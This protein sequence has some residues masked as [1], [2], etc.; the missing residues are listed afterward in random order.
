MLA[1]CSDQATA[2][3]RPSTVAATA[4]RGHDDQNDED[5]DDGRANRVRCDPDNAGLTLPPGFCAVVVADLVMDGRPAAAR[6]MA[7]TPS[8]DLFVAINSPGNRQP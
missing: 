3:I 7:I 8:G 4:D 1:A 5:D 2:P 6:H